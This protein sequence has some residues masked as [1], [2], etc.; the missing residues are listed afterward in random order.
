[1]LETA[2]RGRLGFGVGRRFTHVVDIGEV[3]DRKRAALA[4]HATQTSRPD[5]FP[6]WMVLEDVS[7]GDWLDLLTQPH[8]LYSLTRLGAL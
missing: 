4:A 8:E 6:D 1:M 7:N 2:R 5:D 3:I